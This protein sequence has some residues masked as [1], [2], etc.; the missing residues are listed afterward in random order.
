MSATY[1]CKCPTCGAYLTWEPGT[2]SLVCPYCSASYSEEQLQQFTAE[3]EAAPASGLREYHCT[4]CGAQ[5]VTEET[6]AATRCY[7][8]HSPVVLTDRLTGEFAPD[9][10]I[11]FALD[12]AAAEQAFEKYLKSHRFV[13]RR[14]FTADQREMLSGVY[15]P[16]WLG[17]F[18]GT[19]DFEGTGT[20]VSTT[21]RGSTII[22]TT[23][24]FSVHRTGELSFRQVVRK[25]LGKADR[26]LSDGIHPYRLAESADCAPGY[27]SGFLA[28][29][30][31]V[32]ADAAQADMVQ[33]VTGYAPKLME[34][35][36]TFSTLK[37]KTVFRL[38]GARLRY[39]LLP[40]WVLTYKGEKGKPFYFML[41]G[42]T[43][44]ACGK[45]PV[46]WGRLLAW[47]AALCAAVAGL[48]CAG[49]AWLW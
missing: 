32:D 33:E 26:L 36:G 9:G 7:Y 41:N 2:R 1:T 13:D 45:L 27:L 10:M 6:T 29:K 20:R 19:A 15:Y 39:L 31:D 18:S 3:Q 30:R 34:N 5:I 42:Q 24:Y 49:G 48:L 8:C 22:T 25:A 40:A 21:T 17:D 43:G 35:R 4:S 11:P 28:E 16:Y 44:K 46:S 23:R 12:R 14:F 38:G 47:S 37:G